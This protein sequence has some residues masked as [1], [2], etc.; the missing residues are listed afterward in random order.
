M[1]RHPLEFIGPHTD[2]VGNGNTHLPFTTQPLCLCWIEFPVL[3]KYGAVINK[4]LDKRKQSPAP[5]SKIKRLRISLSS[6]TTAFARG[7]VEKLGFNKCPPRGYLYVPGLYL[8]CIGYHN[9]NEQ[10][11][12]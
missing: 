2:L 5:V 4:I 10:Y 8:L 6:F 12:F 7:S 9:Q 11:T 1:N 3:F